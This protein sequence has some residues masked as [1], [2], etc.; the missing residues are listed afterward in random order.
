[1]RNVIIAY[2]SN[3]TM[4]LSPASGPIYMYCLGGNYVEPERSG[5]VVMFTEL[6]EG[7]SYRRFVV[8]EEFFGFRTVTKAERERA[9]GLLP[10]E[11][12]IRR[13]ANAARPPL[14]LGR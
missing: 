2:Q 3:S 10:S 11:S 1:L 6:L 5:S 14:I 12:A 13:Y 4:G 8:R 9:A 7:V